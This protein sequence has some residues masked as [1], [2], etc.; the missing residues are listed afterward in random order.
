M[1]AKYIRYIAVETISVR[2]LILSVIIGMI[3]IRLTL[4]ERKN[5]ENYGKVANEK[6]Y[7]Y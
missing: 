1:L 4:A 3:I 2:F 6:K 5:Y 7:K